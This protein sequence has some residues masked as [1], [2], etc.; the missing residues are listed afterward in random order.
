[1]D[2]HRRV[3]HHVAV[4]APAR[5]V[6]DLLADVEGWPTI[7]PPSV[8]VVRLERQGQHERIQIWAVANDTPKTWTSVRQVAPA[9]GRIDF[10]QEVSAAPVATM[11]GSWIVEPDDEHSCRVALHHDYSAVDDDPG[12]LDWIDRAVDSNSRAELEALRRRAE[13]AGTEDDLL[14]FEDALQIDSTPGDVFAFINEAGRWRERLPHVAA[15]RLDEPLPGLQMLEMDTRTPGGDLHTTKSMRVCLP[16]ERIVYKQTRLPALMALHTGEWRFE[17]NAHGV[18]ATSRH[19]VALDAAAVPAVLGPDTDMPAARD[20]VRSALGAN[21]RA[22][23]AAAKAMV[24]TGT[25][26]RAADH[27][28]PA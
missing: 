7:F 2:T 26:P 23:L 3:V 21:S 5:E 8:H 28:R 6:F 24:E 10:R 12:A 9:E 14:V 16:D 27:R 22:T 20:F 1:M 15:V 4:D 17:P 13:N 25:S 19:T 11:G 18:L